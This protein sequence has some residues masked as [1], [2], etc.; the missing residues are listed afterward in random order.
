MFNLSDDTQ[1]KF[2]ENPE[3]QVMKQMKT[4]DLA[5]SVEHENRILRVVGS[6]PTLK[7]EYEG[8][9]AGHLASHGAPRVKLNLRSPEIERCRLQSRTWGS[10]PSF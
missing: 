9:S 4:A 5:Q 1:K 7:K 3:S 2:G 10:S 8:E 6:S